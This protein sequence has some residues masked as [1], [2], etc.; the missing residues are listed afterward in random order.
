M[1]LTCLMNGKN[2][3]SNEHLVE[4]LFFYLL[5]NIICIINDD[6]KIHFYVIYFYN[7]VK[8]IKAIQYWLVPNL[9]SIFNGS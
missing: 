8:T 6:L 7:N 1:G 5:F 4:I 3:I 2:D 9:P